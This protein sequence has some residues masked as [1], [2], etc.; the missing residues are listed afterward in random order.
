M[1]KFA[2]M[3]V[4]VGIAD[5]GNLSAAGRQLGLSLTALEKVLGTTLVERTTRH[6]SRMEADL[7]YY[8]RAKQILEEVA[9]AERGLTGAEG[10]SVGP[11]TYYGFRL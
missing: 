2:A 6:L 11:V 1:D 7:L 5:A 4:F 3:R 9:E 10:S 8:E